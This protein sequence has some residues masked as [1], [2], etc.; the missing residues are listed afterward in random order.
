MAT[1][2]TLQLP[3]NVKRIVF[4]ARL[5]AQIGMMLIAAMIVFSLYCLF[6]DP[7][8]I[9]TY[10]KEAFLSPDAPIKLSFWERVL[11]LGLVIVID[12]LGF[13]AFC[14]AYK[15]LTD[16]QNGDIFTLASSAKIRLIGWLIVALSAVDKIVVLVGVLIFGY[17]QTPKGVTIRFEVEEQDI[18]A[19]IF[20][21]LVV[22]IGHVMYQAVLISDENKAII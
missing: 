6:F 13:V 16:Y 7:S 19:I 18:Y 2:D 17:L 10:I 21:L 4:F 3:K 22:V 12:I 20:G 15:L 1:N 14:Y 9:D 8:V 11:G 5:A